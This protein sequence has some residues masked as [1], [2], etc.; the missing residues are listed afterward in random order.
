MSKTSKNFQK[1]Q[2]TG[3]NVLKISKNRQKHRKT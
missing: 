2:K 1:C 3:N